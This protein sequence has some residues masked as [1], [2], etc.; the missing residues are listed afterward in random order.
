MHFISA[1]YV[2]KKFIVALTIKQT[3]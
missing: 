3:I 1:H 2:D